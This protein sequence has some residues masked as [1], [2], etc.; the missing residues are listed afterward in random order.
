MVDFS[1]I[2]S[3]LWPS[4]IL[5]F[6]ILLNKF[7]SLSVE[8]YILIPVI[9]LEDH[10][11]TKFLSPYLLFKNLYIYCSILSFFRWFSL[12]ILSYSIFESYNSFIRSCICFFVK[13]LAPE[14]PSK[15]ASNIS[16]LL[17]SLWDFF[18][19]IFE[20]FKFM[21]LDDIDKS[22]PFLIKESVI[23]W[24]SFCNFSIFRLYISF[25]LLYK[26]F[27]FSYSSLILFIFSSLLELFLLLSFKYSNNNSIFL[28]LILFTESILECNSSIILEKVVN[29]KFKISLIFWPISFLEFSIF[30]N[31]ECSK[32][33]LIKNFN[34]L[35]SLFIILLAIQ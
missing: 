8:L 25:S 31:S 24:F 13:I 16:F 21:L 30:N 1:F 9:I 10:S 20:L 32:N 17:F 4:S 7:I 35:T 6:I 2:I 12:H 19:V 23:N 29:N 14:S 28:F 33:E 5:F 22:I 34:K 15:V 26:I 3:A 11:I 27:N 18:E